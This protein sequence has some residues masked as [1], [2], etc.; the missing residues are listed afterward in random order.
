[1]PKRKVVAT[2]GDGSVMYAPQALW[3]VARYR[4]PITYVVPNN[5]SYAI[6]KSG[7]LSLDLDSAKRG[8]FPGMDLVDPEIDYVSLAR[9]VGVVTT[10]PGATNTLTPL[11]ESYAGSMPVLVVMSDV[12]S[13]LVGREVGALH[14]V[15]NQIECFR[16]VTRWAEALTE[17]AAIPTAL[18]GAFHLLRTGRPGPIAISIP[19]DFLTAQVEAASSTG[20]HGRRPPCH[21][22]EIK[23]AAGLLRGAARPLIIAGGGVIAAGA[24]AELQALARRLDAPVLTTVMGRGAISE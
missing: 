14:E 16:P 13:H 23:E 24:E 5:T 2:I 7:M 3:T 22:S 20:G 11:V 15:P 8:I 4:L 10:G 17:A 21:V 6:L 9:A 1:L 19:N 12:A 18:H